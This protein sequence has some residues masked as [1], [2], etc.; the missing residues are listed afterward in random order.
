[1]RFFMSSSSCRPSIIGVGRRD[2]EQMEVTVKHGDTEGHGDAR[3]FFLITKNPK[4]TKMRV[5]ESEPNVSVS[6]CE[7]R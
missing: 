4:G 7:I 6:P 3:S 2:V 1:M 5:H